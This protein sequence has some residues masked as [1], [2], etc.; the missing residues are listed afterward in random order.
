MTPPTRSKRRRTLPVE[1]SRNGKC[2]PGFTGAD[3]LAHDFRG[4]E[5]IWFQDLVEELVAKERKRRCRDDA[6]EA[7]APS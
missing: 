1:A 3:F 2:P 4:E 6:K 5:A 7:T